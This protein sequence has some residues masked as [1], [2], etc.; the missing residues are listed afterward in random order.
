MGCLLL[1]IL[2]VVLAGAGVW[3]T[4]GLTIG[5]IGLGLTLLMA[6]LVGWA[7]DQVIPG[8]LPGGWLG[9]VLTGILGGFVG[10][11]VFNL[12]HVGRV[13]PVIFGIDV[14]PAFVGAVIIAAVAQM[15]TTRR[16]PF[17]HY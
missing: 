3:L 2:L 7:A 11:L 1:L 10:H 9:A 12:L 17:A 8:R 5:L 13:G 14:V 4:I 15:L 6:G 16:S